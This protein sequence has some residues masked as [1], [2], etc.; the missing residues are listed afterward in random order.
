MKTKWGGYSGL[1]YEIVNIFL[2]YRWAQA[3]KNEPKMFIA[4][5]QKSK[6]KV[7]LGQGQ[8]KKDMIYLKLQNKVQLIL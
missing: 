7:I 3:W 2:I 4:P 6:Q 1:D 5:K 8:G